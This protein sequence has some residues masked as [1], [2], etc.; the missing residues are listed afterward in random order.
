MLVGR[1]HIPSSVLMRTTLLMAVGLWS[2]CATLAVSDAR[3]AE[4]G[5]VIAGEI[6]NVYLKRQDDVSVVTQTV[7]LER[8]GRD[9]GWWDQMM[10]TYWPDSRVD[11]S[12]YHGDGPGFVYGSRKIYERGSRPQ[13]RMYAPVVRIAGNKAHVEV[14]A[15]SWSPQQIN[16]KKVNLYADMR[17]NYRLEKRGDEWRILS[18][19]P[20]Y[21]HTEL[22]S[23][24]SGEAI[25]IPTK[26]LQQFRPAYAALS[27][28][29]SQ[30]GIK[31][32]QDEL[33]LDRPEGVEAYYTSVREWMAH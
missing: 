24:I 19:N 25:I 1:S 6:D 12:W 8:Q 3:A 28:A 20:I 5:A 4:E 15:R 17:L 14:A 23:D 16:G 33:G 27:W 26:D 13:H 18:L 22:T 29:L 10:S 11:L 2:C 9:R 32:S 21:E 31:T 30:Q 7:L